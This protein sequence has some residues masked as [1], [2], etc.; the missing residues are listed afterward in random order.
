[1]LPHEGP[2]QLPWFRSSGRQLY[3]SLEQLK[4]IKPQDRHMC[5]FMVD[6]SLKAPLG[7]DGELGTL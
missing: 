1:M 3:L 5:A 2:A 6:W 7:E 4:L